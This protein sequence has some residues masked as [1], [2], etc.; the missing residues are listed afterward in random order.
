MSPIARLTRFCIDHR[1]FVI[2]G[3]IAVA[4]AALALSSAVGTRYSNNFTLPGTDAQ[5]AADLLQRNFPAQ[6]G[7]R[8]QIVF[9]AT[10]G[11]GARPGGARADQ[12]RCCAQVAKLPHVTGVI[13][14]YAAGGAGADLRRRPHRLRDGHLRRKR[15][16]AAQG[17]RRTRDLASPAEPARA[18]LQV[19]LG[20]QAIEQTQQAGLASRPPSGCSRRS[21]CCCSP[22][23]RSSR[24]ACRS[25][26]P[27]FGLGT[28]LGLIGWPSQVVDMPDFSTELAAMIGLGVGIDYALFIVTRFREDYARRA[29]A[30][31]ARR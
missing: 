27:L 4:I 11:H 20:G 24:W 16:R 28:G 13:S 18:R 21:S 31:C 6:A 14:P 8:D 26:P 3:W 10:L 22:S 7:D 23:A 15:Q 12:R 5:R 1:R 17:R 19:E 9:A 29:I 30:T 25:S 2:L